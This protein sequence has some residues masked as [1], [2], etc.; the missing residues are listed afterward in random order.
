[1]ALQL[2]YLQTMNEMASESK[3]NTIFPVPLE[4][5]G[6]LVEAMKKRDG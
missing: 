1:M 2:R 5:F 4:L 3:T 6:P